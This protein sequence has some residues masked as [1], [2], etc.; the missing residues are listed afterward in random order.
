MRIFESEQPQTPSWTELGRAIGH[1]LARF[2]LGFKA[3]NLPVCVAEGMREVQAKNLRPAFSTRFERK[4]VQ[5]RLNAFLRQ[6]VTDRGVTP[7]FLESID[8]DECPVL[9]IK[10]THATGLPTDWSVDR[11][12]NDGAYA[13]G[14]LAVMS[15]QANTAKAARSFSEV[16]QISQ[17]ACSFE[18]LEFCE[19]KRLACLM[20]GPCFADDPERV[21]TLPLLTPIPK[22]TIR[23]A[24]QQVQ[25]ALTLRAASQSGKNQLIRYFQPTART[26]C[27]RVRFM[28]LA[29]AVHQGL[30]R[31]NSRWDVWLEPAVM[32]RL[33][34]WR[35]T[36]DGQSWGHAGEIARQLTGARNVGTGRLKPWMLASKGYR[37]QHWEEPI[38]SHV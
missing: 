12:N 35:H 33:V 8:V 7:A 5:I 31:V 22:S 30:K 29:E 14:N 13:P 32:N 15:T 3:G 26:E 9:R 27:A 16:I 20:L 19:W 17:R 21:P 2:N 6:R 37:V 18:G 11:L 28:F 24:M 34:E 38:K 36:L 23:L 1:D 4:W 25:Y 10:L